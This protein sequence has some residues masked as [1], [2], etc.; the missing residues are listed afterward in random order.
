MGSTKS[1]QCEWMDGLN[2][3]LKAAPVGLEI[4]NRFE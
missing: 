3:N 2:N 1:L 4:T